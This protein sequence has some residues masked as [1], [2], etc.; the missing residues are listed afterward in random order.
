MRN[1]D[2]DDALFGRLR[3]LVQAAK[4]MQRRDRRS[5]LALEADIRMVR[6]ELNARCR[7]L[8]EQMRAASTRTAAISAYARI[9]RMASGPNHRPTNPTE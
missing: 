5:V 4:T 2:Q 9:G 6:G 3:H 8:T 1:D 7:M